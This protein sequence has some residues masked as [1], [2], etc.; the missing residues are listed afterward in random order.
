MT[1]TAATMQQLERGRSRLAELPAARLAEVWRE[2]IGELRDPAPGSPAAQVRERMAEA[3]GFSPPALDAGLE[4]V[5]DSVAGPDALALF[6]NPPPAAPGSLLVFLAATPPGLAVQALLPALALRRPM[7]LKSSSA[8][9]H[10]APLLIDRL[11]QREPILGE[12]YAAASWPGGERAVEDPLLAAAGRVIAYGGAEAMASLTPRCANFFPFGPKLSLAI[13]GPSAD[14]A[15]VAPGLAR[16]V[17]LLDQ[18]GCLSVQLIL[19]TGDPATLGHPL[20]AALAA[21]AA[22]LPPGPATPAALA[23]IRL[24][25]EEAALRGQWVAPLPLRQGTVIAESAAAP[26]A[27]SPGLR[28]VR[29]HP[30]R[31]LDEAILR[32]RP[33]QGF[34]QGVVLA[35]GAEI[36]ES[37]LRHLGVTRVAPPGELQQA[38]L[39]RWPNGGRPALEVF[40]G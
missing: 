8:E 13:L 26:L 23:E 3:L 33:W 17:A 12:A 22:D 28:T 30:L 40:A 20:A 15:A 19:T 39:A 10:F 1:P 36:L 5:L 29:I 2:T 11:A 24:L 4:I 34:L 25:R 9:P 14:P 27:P 31:S 7:L 38:G 37:A 21:A 18:R 6:E 35:G 16:D 32:L